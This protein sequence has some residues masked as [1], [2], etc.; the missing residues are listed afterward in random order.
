MYFNFINSVVENP[1]S[2]LGWLVALWLD[3]INQKQLNTFR[4][5]AITAGMLASALSMYSFLKAIGVDPMWSVNRAIKWCAKPEYV[6]LDTSPFFSMMRYAGFFFGMGFGFNSESFKKNSKL[7][8][9]LAM[10]IACAVLSVGMCKLSEKVSL[11]RG[12]MLF[13]YV[14]AFLLNAI[15]SYVMIAVVPNIVAKVWNKKQKTQ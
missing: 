12:S 9:S 10:R 1:F 6:H 5:C 2:F 11:I 14:Q 4:Y 15:L 13:V 8:Y 7:N 3:N